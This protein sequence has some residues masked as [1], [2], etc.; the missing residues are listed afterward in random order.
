MLSKSEIAELTER[1]MQYL[2]EKGVKVQHPSVLVILGQAGAQVD[3][4]AQIVRFPRELVEAAL[5][6]APK[7][8]TLAAPIPKSD[9]ALPHPKGDFYTCTGTG[10]RGII[11]PESGDYRGLTVSDVR[12]WGRLV[13]ALDNIDLCAFPTPTDAP[14]ET[15]DIHS[16]RALLENC[17]KHI[18][19]QP[20]TEETLPYIFELAAARAGS[21]ESLEERPIV[22]IIACSLTPFQFK[23]MDI[24]VIVQACQ[25]GIPIHAS[26]LPVIGGT[27]PITIAGAVLVA[28]IEVLAMVIIAQIIRPGIPVIGL[29]T[30]LNMDMQSGRAVKA[31]PEAMLVNAAS[32]QFIREAFQIPTHTA[33]FTTDTFQPDGQAMTEHSLYAFMVASAGASILGRAGELEAAMTVSPIQLIVD[34]EVVGMLKHLHRGITFNAEALAWGDI[35]AVAPG[36]HFLETEHTLRHCRDAFQPRL[37]L[38]QPRDEWDAIGCPDLI[39]RAQE[40]YRELIADAKQPEILDSVREEMG[41]IVQEADLNLVQQKCIG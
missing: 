24:E 1:V 17:E 27:S 40:Q 36:G 25:Y 11:D 41:R 5:K 20:H 22:S 4:G 6:K 29:A 26:S 28:G 21:R 33:G 19:I 37:F 12:R 8:F 39:T 7:S 30:A 2:A 35:Q 31:S 3:Y 15:V 14:P 23:S 13:N 38:R 16:L 10:A 32:A 18:W 34:N 9:L